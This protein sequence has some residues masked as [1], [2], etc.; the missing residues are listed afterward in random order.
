MKEKNIGYLLLVC[1]L[2]LLTASAVMLWKIAYGTMEPP[3][4]F[5]SEENIT[6]TMA[7]GVRMHMPM[8]PQINRF[9]NLSLG[10]MLMFFLASVGGRIGL[11]GVKLINGPAI[12]PPPKPQ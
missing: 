6:F 9:G 11:I 1:G 3:Q 12:I 4:A 7:S 2:V 8:P 10:F 5:G